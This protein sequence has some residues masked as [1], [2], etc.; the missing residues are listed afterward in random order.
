MT[1][2]FL[3][4]SVSTHKMEHWKESAMCVWRNNSLILTCIQ[5]SPEERKSLI[6]EQSFGVHIA[7]ACVYHTVFELC[8][9]EKK[10]KKKKKV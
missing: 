4:V 2:S 8:M 3:V 1:F 6:V 9:S 7:V 10:K 5:L